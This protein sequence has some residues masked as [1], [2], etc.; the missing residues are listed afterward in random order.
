[1][2]YLQIPLDAYDRLLEKDPKIIQMDICDFIKSLKKQQLSSA[3][4]SLYVGALRKFFDMNDVTSLNW[5]KITSFQGEHEKIAED[6]PY[7]HNEIHILTQK[8]TQRNRAIILLMASSGCR[9]GAIPHIR[10]KD[11]E[12]NDNYN[13]YKITYYPSSK[14]SR[15]YSY[16]TPMPQGN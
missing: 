13:I 1:M 14:Q 11:L 15:Y 10:I 16:S 8:T 3:T 2:S 5:K 9:L 7:T 4:V 12:P 6:R